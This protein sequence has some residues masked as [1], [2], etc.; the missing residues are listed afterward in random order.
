MTCTATFNINTFSLT[1]TKTGTGSGTVTASGINCGTDCNQSYSGGSSI[2][3]S[4]TPAAGSMFAGWSGIGCG[5]TVTVNG[6]MSCTATFN[7]NSFTLTVNKGGTGSGTVTAS[8]INCGTDCSHSY[9]NGSSII[10]TASP[11]AGSTFAGWSGTNC[12]STVTLNSNISCQATFNLNNFTLTVSKAGTGSGTVMGNGI[13][14]GGDCSES[15][16]SGTQVSLTATAATGSTFLRWEGPDCSTVTVTGNMT[17]L[18][19]F[20]LNASDYSLTISK[21][22]T[23]SGTVMADG[24]NC[25]SDCSESYAR[26]TRVALTATPANGSVFAGWTGD[27]CSR[28]MTVSGNMNCTATF[29]SFSLIITKAGTGSGTVMTA[30]INCGTDCTETYARVTRVTLRASAANGSFFA[31]WT[32]TGCGNR[33]RV[34]DHMTCTATFHDTM[35]LKD[36]IGIYRPSTGE[37]FLDQNGNGA[38]ENG[39]DVHAQTFIAAG[40][41]PVVGE[42][43][44]TGIAQ[45]GLFQPST[46]QWHLDLKQNNLLADSCNTD[47]CGWS[48]GEENDT[49]LVGNWDS[50][51]Q[52]RVGVFRSS[53]GYWYLDRNGDGDL[54]SCNRDR[55]IHLKNYQ[56]GDLPVVGDW[57]GN[58][59]SQVGLF[60]PSSGEWFL[61]FNNNEKWDGC[62]RDLCVTAFGS[63]GD[64]PVSGDWDGTGKSKIGIFRP[65]TGQ[66]FLDQ[67]GNGVWDKCSVDVCLSGFGVAG[68]IPVVGKW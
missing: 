64:L 53:T 16:P 30:G 11:A 14:C 45:I 52:I 34:N 9:P 37:W 12:G 32:G 44:G 39:L 43:S 13:N 5:S 65:S 24:I 63:P 48:F 15:Y 49:P 59:V 27:G 56:A 26:V 50:R 25:G 22:G 51:G 6:N 38:W 47:G 60:R 31:G 46:L 68:D 18:A 42:W 66:W 62:G 33:V 61:D 36:R 58:G 8:G 19:I 4:A 2:A 17:C 10:L 21:A 1:V 29:K 28:R 40:M 3:L 23:G 7:L 67:N 41:K 35:L 20:Q 57:N 54:D 55:C